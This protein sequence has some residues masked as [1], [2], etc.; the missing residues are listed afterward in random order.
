MADKFISFD[1]LHKSGWVFIDDA[2]QHTGPYVAIMGISS[3][4][5]DVSDCTA[6]KL[7]DLADFT[8]PD[9]TYIP[10]PWEVF[11]LTSG[12]AIAFKEA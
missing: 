2:A 5:V 9:G 4:I 10:G 11:S 1:I 6:A 3:A 12:T 8:I 7:E